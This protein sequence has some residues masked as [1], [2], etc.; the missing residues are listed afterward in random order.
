MTYKL[1]LTHFVKADE[2]TSLSLYSRSLSTGLQ[3]SE[4]HSIRVLCSVLAVGILL[5]VYSVRMYLAI[6][7]VRADILA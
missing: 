6:K 4:T 7:H 3:Y 1:P 2:S 5:I